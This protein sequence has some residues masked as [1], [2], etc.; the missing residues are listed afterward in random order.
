VLVKGDIHA[1]HPNTLRAN[2]QPAVAPQNSSARKVNDFG[3]IRISGNGASARLKFVGQHGTLRRHGAST[4]LRHLI[5]RP[6]PEGSY[7]LAR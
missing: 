2:H 7:P 1:P 5:Y 4:G 6:R 3:V